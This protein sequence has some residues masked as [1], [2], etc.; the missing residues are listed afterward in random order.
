MRA[1]SHPQFAVRDAGFT[2]VAPG[3]VTVVARLDP[4]PTQA[5]TSG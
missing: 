4:Q 3:T 2:E 5:L 1:P